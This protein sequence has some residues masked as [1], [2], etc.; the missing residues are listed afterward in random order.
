M[1]GLGLSYNL[2]DLRRRQLKLRTQKAETDYAQNQLQEQKVLLANGTNQAFVEMQTAR[3]RLV[4]IPKQLKAASEG[5]RQK[6][7]LYRNGLTDIIELDAALNILYR[8]ET[9]FARAK[10][11]FTKALFEQ[12]I[13]DNQTAV[14]L[15]LLK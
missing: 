4:E 8:A 13:A 15:N 10:Y 1:V 7:S 9:D 2:F 3:Q 11:D 5:Y 12:A 14:V 6:L